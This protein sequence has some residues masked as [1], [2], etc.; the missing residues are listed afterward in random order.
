MAN[1]FLLELGTEEIPAKFSP[2]AMT[3]LEEQARKR[4]NDLRLPFTDLKIFATPR[5]LALL[6]TGLEEKQQDLSLEVK[7]PAV[8]AAYDANGV[9]TKAVQG[10]ARGQGV[11]VEDLFVQELKGVQY[12]YA[13]KSETGLETSALLP[14]L[15]KDLIHGLRFP[16]PMRWGDLE[17]HFARPI[18]WIVALYGTEVVPFEFVGL[19]SGRTSRGHRTLATEVVTLRQSSDYR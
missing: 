6:V 12:V 16:Q 11:S 19:E 14:Q 3:Q 13:H 17:F 1:D 5:R 18:R 8:K 9:P 10:F 7:G 2:V 15:A 4:L